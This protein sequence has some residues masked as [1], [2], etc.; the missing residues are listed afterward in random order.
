MRLKVRG[1]RLSPPILRG[2]NFGELNIFG[3]PQAPVTVELGNRLRVHQ[4]HDKHW[5]GCD[6][7]WSD[8]MCFR[9]AREW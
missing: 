3:H 4:D 2:R 7:S 9:G 1:V 6:A 5:N 8:E